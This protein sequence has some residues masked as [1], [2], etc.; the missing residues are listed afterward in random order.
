MIYIYWISIASAM[1]FIAIGD[2]END[3][4]YKS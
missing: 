2:S 1:I 3:R 4:Q